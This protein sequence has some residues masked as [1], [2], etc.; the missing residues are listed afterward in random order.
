MRLLPLA[1]LTGATIT[2]IVAR[3]TLA[4]GVLHY[5]IAT[6]P[7]TLDPTK[8]TGIPEATVIINCFD[9]L[10]RTDPSGNE[11]VPRVAERWDISPDGRTYTFHLRESF[12]SDGRPVTAGDFEFAFKRLLDPAQAAEYA[13]ML[14][15]IDAA[16]DYIS[17][18]EKDPSHVGVRALDPQTLEIRLRAATPFFLKLL[19][20]QTYMPLPR[21]VVENNPDWALSPQTYVCNGAFT[22]AEWRHH[23]RLMFKKNPRHWD[24]RNVA[25]DELIFRT[26]ESVSTELAMFETGELD[27]TYQVPTESI[28]RARKSPDFRSFPQ[29]GTYFFCFNTKRR[30]FDDPRVRRAF[31]L[32]VDR[33][34]IADK[35]C[36]GGE[37]PALAFVSP[38][39]RDADG[40]SDFRD[41]GGDLFRA[42]D[43]ETARRLLAEAGYPGGRGFPHVAYFYNDDERHRKIALVLQNMWKK[44]LGVLVEL[45]V[46][47]WKVLLTHRRSGGYDVCRHGWTGDY[48]DPMTF[49]DM[50]ITGSGLNDCKWS[51]AE[52]DRLIAAAREELDP[53]K[54]MALLHTAEKVLMDE[55]PIAPLFYYVTLYMQKPYASGIVRNALGYVYFDRARIGSK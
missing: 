26:I 43:V 10:V 35:I 11:I 1:L 32:A 13:I 30:P 28:A 29:I 25:L 45:R 50:F 18:K 49:L 41:V 19:P 12:W 6:E 17:G 5:N 47:E 20:H 21:H 48:A 37:R 23:D 14:F 8:A 42:P 40:R 33:R 15:P 54:R 55:M 7:E 46:E 53:A 9:G 16:E 52:Y 36:Q 34:V 2:L 24:A 38:S 22:L 27:M 39:I 31:A 51:N 4:D 3:Q 44:N